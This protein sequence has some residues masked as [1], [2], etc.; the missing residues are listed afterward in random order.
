LLTLTGSHQSP[1]QNQPSENSVGHVDN[2]G[3]VPRSLVLT[4]HPDAVQVPVHRAA[5]TCKEVVNLHFAAL[6]SMDLSQPPPEP[7]DAFFSLQ[8]SQT[9]SADER[10]SQHEHW[11]LAKAF[12]D[13][14]RGVRGSLEKAYFF[15]E[16]LSAGAFI[17]KTNSTLDDVLTPFRT[18]AQ[19]MNFPDLLGH[20]NQRLETP[21]VFA[22][23]YSSMQAAR[24]CFEHRNG[25]VGSK[26]AKSDGVLTM[27]FPGL[28][29]FVQQDGKEVEVYKNFR[30]ERE[31]VLQ[32]KMEV[33]E[34]IFRVGERLTISAADFNEIAF[35]CVQFGTALALQLPKAGPLLKAVC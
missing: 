5:A 20:V 8:I 17:A 11:I 14:M 12:Q 3:D 22:K 34:R 16:L 10:R 6:S 19:K 21:L 9:L 29:F 35:S 1:Q 23:A 27:Y 18:K 26:D 13:L 24:N 28:K 33:R 30:T 31:T 25:I 2:V 7:Q 32:I 4:L 15:I